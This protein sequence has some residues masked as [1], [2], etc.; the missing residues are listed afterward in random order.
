[1]SVDGPC[2]PVV[3]NERVAVVIPEIPQ[4][5]ELKQNV[6][7]RRLH[8]VVCLIDTHES[9]PANIQWGLHDDPL[10]NLIAFRIGQTASI[11]VKSRD[12]A[13]AKK[14]PFLITPLGAC[15]VKIVIITLS[16]P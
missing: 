10:D 8:S 9:I 12:V 1:M 11:G 15:I 5:R 16:C 7:G 2:R 4:S 13:V 3:V 6:I 14:K